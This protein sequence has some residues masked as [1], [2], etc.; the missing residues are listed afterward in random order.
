MQTKRKAS[1]RRLLVVADFTSDVV[2]R[3][4]RPLRLCFHETGVLTRLQR[5]A[6]SAYI[7]HR[8]PFRHLNTQAEDVVADQLYRARK[9]HRQDLQAVKSA[10]AGGSQAR[11]SVEDH[12]SSGACQR[13]PLPQ[14]LCTCVLK[15]GVLRGRAPLRSPSA[16]NKN[17]R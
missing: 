6:L 9:Q 11:H 5:R 3:L 1:L 8:Q 2:R 14:L 10:T 12:E 15:H 7:P 13:V 4:R 16:L 17:A